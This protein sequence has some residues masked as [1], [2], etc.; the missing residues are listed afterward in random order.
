MSE[1]V[2]LVGMSGNAIEIFE[3]ASRQFRICAI[4]DDAPAHAGRT[5]EGVPIRPLSALGDYP[6]AGVACLIGSERS[7]RMR[8]DLIARLN[9][10][11]ERFVTIV[12]PAARV[13]RFARIGRGTVVYAGVTITSNAVIGDH[14]LILPHTIVHHDVVIGDHAIVGSNVTLAGSVHIG[15]SAFVGSAS[16][17]RNGVTI[18][19]GALVGMGANVT[20][21]V[22]DG[23]IVAGNPA[24]PMVRAGGEGAG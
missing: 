4:L 22:A 2:V 13:S 11:R 15:D 10:P 14:V 5:F 19:E 24:R 8:R 7:H 3:A 9:V 16:S 23:T 6:D 20:R 1:P 21:D 12:D 18:G 17:V